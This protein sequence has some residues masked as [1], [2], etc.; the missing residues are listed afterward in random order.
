MINNKPCG[1]HCIKVNNLSVTLGNNKIL[2]DID[3]HIHCGQITSIIGPNGAGKTTLLKA[4]LGEI[5]HSGNIESKDTNNNRTRKLIIGYVPQ[6]L[7]IDKNTPTTVYDL[8]ASLNTNRPIFLYR[9][10]S[11]YNKLKTQLKIFDIDNLIDNKICDLSGGE[12]QRV[13][14]AIATYNNPNLLILDEPVS[15]VDNNGLKLFYENI[16]YLK[17]N[18]DMSII[19]VSHD[20]EFVRKYSDNVILINKKIIKDG[21]VKDVFE[22]NEFKNIF[23]GEQN[24]SNI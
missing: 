16:I 21:K 11:L 14:L 15:G 9:D 8:F 6:K 10:K 5:K 23:L 2:D 12:L 20:L 3:I 19:I 7:N 18:Y 17:E 4:I 13:L 24:G 1:F 22:S